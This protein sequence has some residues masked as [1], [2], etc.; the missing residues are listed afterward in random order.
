MQFYL[1]DTVV[2]VCVW[3]GRGLEMSNRNTV[4]LGCHQ[5][6]DSLLALVVISFLPLV[7]PHHSLYLLCPRLTLVE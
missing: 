1:F 5:E 3:G 7:T 6:E 4:F 2:L